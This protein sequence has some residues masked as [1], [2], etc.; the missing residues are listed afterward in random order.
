MLAYCLGADA[1][2]A[3][4]IFAA[5]LATAGVPVAGALAATRTDGQGRHAQ[6]RQM[7]LRLL[8]GGGQTRISQDLGPGASGCRLDPGA[9]ENAVQRV[10]AALPGA[11]LLIVNRF[12]RTEA[13]GR[14]FRTLIG[15]ALAEGVPVLTTLN[16]KWLADFRAFAQGMETEL[17]PDPAALLDWWQNLDHWA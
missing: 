17:P 3:L 5:R 12:G 16:P 14:G 10:A 4:A 1:D 15:T 9:L 11:R 13:E 8:P 6:G 7:D 2:A